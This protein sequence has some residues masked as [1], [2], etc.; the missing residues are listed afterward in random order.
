MKRTALFL[1]AI[2]AFSAVSLYAQTF[3]SGF[4]V[5]WKRDNYDN[6]ITLTNDTLKSSSQGPFW[7]LAEKSGDS[8]TLY[9]ENSPAWY[10][11]ITIKLVNGNL[12]ISGDSGDG[13]DNWNG[14]WK[15]QSTVAQ[16]AKTHFDNGERLYFQKNYDGAIREFTEAIRL[17]PKNAEA[18]SQRG[19]VYDT[20]H[21]YERAAADYEAALRIDPDNWARRYLPDARRY[22]KAQA[23]NRYDPSQFIVVSSDFTPS[24]YVKADLFDAVAVAEK[25]SPNNSYLG[26]V[27]LGVPSRNFVSDVVFVSQNGTDIV[28]RTEDNAIRQRMKVGSRTGL[29]SG[30][31]VRVYY[32]AYNLRDWQVVAIEKR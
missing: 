14:T 30:Q 2:L 1:T 31:K 25:L 16:A 12:V 8:Y 13:Q 10:I 7:I 9:Q 21:D 29:T 26:G 19:L 22:A 5:V 11:T 28:F 15:K 27:N 32:I 18:Y 17:D 3:P 6:T 24:I 20:K 23:A 4:A